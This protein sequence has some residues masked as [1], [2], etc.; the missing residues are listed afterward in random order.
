MGCEAQSAA[1]P[2]W[3]REHLQRSRPFR[4][5][6]APAASDLSSVALKLRIRIC[7]VRQINAA[8]NLLVKLHIY[9][10][11]PCVVLYRAAPSNPRQRPS[12]RLLS[13]IMSTM[14][15]IMTIQH[16]TRIE[17]RKIG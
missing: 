14:P 7:S 16:E 8:G 1:I 4:S 3:Y 11:C 12:H 17:C 10:F 9:L 13:N 15:H 2:G 5:R 6:D